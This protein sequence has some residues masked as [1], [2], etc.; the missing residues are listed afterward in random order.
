MP[1]AGNAGSGR[2]PAAAMGDRRLG[3]LAKAHRIM[4]SAKGQGALEAVPR[5]SARVTDR[6]RATR[7][8]ENAVMADH[9]ALASAKAREDTKA[10]PRPS[11]RAFGQVRATR[12]RVDR[13]AAP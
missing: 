11:A 10:V 3:R 8:R 1:T 9:R 12:R 2:R 7:R 6:E 13:K 4:N 5:L